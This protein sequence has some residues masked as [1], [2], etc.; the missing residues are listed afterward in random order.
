MD[1]NILDRRYLPI[2]GL[3]RLQDLAPFQIL[4]NENDDSIRKGDN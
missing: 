1:S 2:H 3:I 4:C